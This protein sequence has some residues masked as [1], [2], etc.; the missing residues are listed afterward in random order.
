MAIV[1]WII[2]KRS[3]GHELSLI[4]QIGDVLTVPHK[5]RRASEP[6]HKMK[7]PCFW[8][9]RIA[10]AG[11]HDVIVVEVADR[12]IPIVVD[13]VGEVVFELREIDYADMEFLNL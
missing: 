13:V 8:I 4:V 12:Q 3:T 1:I 11:I 10:G 5:V 2:F 9:W 6:S 7:F